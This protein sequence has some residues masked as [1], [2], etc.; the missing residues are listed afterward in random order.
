MRGFVTV[1]LVVALLPLS[2]LIVGIA[3]GIAVGETDHGIG[4]SGAIVAVALWLAASWL[5][6]RRRKRH[7]A[8]AGH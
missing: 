1:L 7:Q 6:I 5:V 3:V 2:F 8:V 4:A